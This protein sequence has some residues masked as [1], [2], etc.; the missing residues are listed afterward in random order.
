[1][2]KGAIFSIWLA[3]IV[4]LLIAV[5]SGFYHKPHISV[6]HSHTAESCQLC[7]AL[8]KILPLLTL[9]LL[10]FLAI[11]QIQKHESFVEPTKVFGNLRRFFFHSVIDPPIAA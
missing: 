8:N 2:K 3:I 9:A 4:L 11:P 10:F 7:I 1:M 5:T 6:D